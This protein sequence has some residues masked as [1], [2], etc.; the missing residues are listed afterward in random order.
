MI[1][2]NTLIESVEESEELSYLIKKLF[3]DN[4]RILLPLAQS[5]DE[6]DVEKYVSKT[7]QICEA[8]SKIYNNNFPQYIDN[9]IKGL[10][11]HSIEF[12]RLQSAFGRTKEYAAESAE[13]VFA[14]VYDSPKIMKQYLDGLLL[15]YVAWPNH[16][17]LLNYFEEQYVSACPTGNC[18]EVGPGHGFLSLLLLQQDKG[19]EL[20]G[21]DISPHSVRY[22]QEMLIK[23]G[24]NEN[25]F[26]IKAADAT[27][28]INADTKFDA[29]IIAEVL[30][31]ITRPDLLLKEAVL[32]ATKNTRMFMSTVVNIESIDHLYLYRTLD[33]VS[34]M[35]DKCGLEIISQLNMP[36]NLGNVDYDAYEV[37][38][39][40]KL[41]SSFC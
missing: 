1:D 38:I 35:F 13:E 4:E 16:Y 17:K 30:E 36:L 14:E 20:L 40:C 28:G 25:R 2:I 24:I 8:L 23:H 12:L 18:L 5:L 37:A 27:K 29:I 7:R 11:F 19:R 32:H 33:E 3:I 15:T 21:L 34:E 31:H 9:A 39:I 22:T 26:K 6:S 41:K 10:Q